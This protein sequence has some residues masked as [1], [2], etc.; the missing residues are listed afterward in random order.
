M[1]SL[2]TFE[3]RFPFAESQIVP[4]DRSPIRRN[5]PWPAATDRLVAAAGVQQDLGERW[6]ECRR[7]A[8]CIHLGEPV[9]WTAIYKDRTVPRREHLHVGAPG[10]A[11]RS[12]EGNKASGS[13]VRSQLLIDIF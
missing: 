13:E 6:V 3:S 8:L 2:V 5:R 9:F 11:K 4:L 7:V 12:Y 1:L 10:T